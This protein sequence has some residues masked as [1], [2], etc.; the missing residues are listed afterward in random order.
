MKYA[1]KLRGVRRA[2]VH[3]YPHGVY[4]TVGEDRA[5]HVWAVASG[6][7]DPAYWLERMNAR[8]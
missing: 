6:Q 1:A 2:P 3:G 5:V 4:F 8:R 7:R